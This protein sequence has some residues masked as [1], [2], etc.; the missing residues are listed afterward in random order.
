MKLREAVIK[1]TCKPTEEEEKELAPFKSLR[2]S[3]RWE[4]DSEMGLILFIGIANDYGIADFEISSMISVDQDQ[5]DWKK[6]LYKEVCA[7]TT[8]SGLRMRNKTTLVKNYLRFYDI[9]G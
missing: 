1:N 9:A 6:N 2:T 5:I 4:G 7:S 8:L 3:R